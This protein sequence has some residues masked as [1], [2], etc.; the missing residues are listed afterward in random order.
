MGKS[1]TGRG[2]SLGLKIL[3]VGALVLVLGLP[4]LFVNML[5]WERANRADLVA[6]EVGAA[7][8]G[9]QI[10]RGPFLLLP[11]DITETVL[12]NTGEEERQE[13]R[14]RTETL[15]ISPETL[16]ISVNL[17]TDIRRRAIYDVP[18]YQ[19]DLEFSGQ[20]T[21]SDLAPLT[22][23]NGE[24]RW[25][26]AELVLAFSDLRGIN[27]DLSFTI[28]GRPDPLSF[29]PGSGF[30]RPQRR[31]TEES[32]RGVSARLPDLTE[33]SSFDFHAQ[34]TL[35][36]AQRLS[37]TPSGRQTRAAIRGDWPHPGFD[38]AYLPQDRTITDQDFE[39]SWS[40][41]YLARGVPA[42]WREGAGFNMMR[43][44]DA[45]FTVNLVTPTDGYVRVSR[46]L[47][48]AFFFLSFT[49]LMVFLIEAN[50]KKRIHAAQYVLIGLA[51]VIFYLMLLALS[52]HWLI[53][54]AYLAASGATIGISGLYAM[55]A[56]KSFG[57]GLLVALT[58]VLT[59]ALQY[60]LLL[61]EDYALLIGAG[62][63]FL[64]LALTM[65]MTRN[66]NWYAVSD[67]EGSS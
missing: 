39:A 44:D 17:D 59:Y 24:I 9:P 21:P 6:Q 2:R 53:Q 20:F 31:G 34:L 32:W 60:M 11:V 12:V 40:V 51:Q 30:D 42:N 50:G 22:P 28:D 38:G 54:P 1:N 65:Y 25:S 5:A 29:E 37:L 55:T 67:D 66:V 45:L 23:R 16:D 56:F 14:I 49:L 57:R 13:T 64:S 58:L 4:L 41:P 46:A 61:L 52:E 36:G 62:L 8:G 27:A 35:S 48:Y 43:A 47:K 10:V 33:G 18:V 7:Y 3:L 63:A 26:G 15:V 19:A